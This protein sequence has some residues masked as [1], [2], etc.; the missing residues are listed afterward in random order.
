MYFRSQ[1]EEISLIKQQFY[2]MP[3]AYKR[4]LFEQL[5]RG[6]YPKQHN[7]ISE[8]EKLVGSLLHNQVISNLSNR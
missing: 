1:W 3:E 2:R 6:E 8:F 5:T 7:G 4:Q